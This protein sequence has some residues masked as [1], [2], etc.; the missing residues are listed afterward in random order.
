MMHAEAPHCMPKN[1]LIAGATGLVG[2]LLLSFCLKKD[3]YERIYVLL[4]RPKYYDDPRVVPVLVDY[5]RLPTYAGK[6]QAHHYYCCLGS[7]IRAAGSKANFYN[8]DALYVHY[9]AQLAQKDDLCSTFI[10]LTSVGAN[11][12]S[13]FFYCRVK[14]QAEELVGGARISGVHILRPS[15]LLGART[16]PRFYE[17]VA[18]ACI[19]VLRSLRLEAF[20]AVFAIAAAH[21]ARSMYHIAQQEQPGRRTYAAREIYRISAG[22]NP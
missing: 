7:T 2:K 11:S 22:M 14:G 19:A 17:E 13:S 12:R 15:V 20:A 9:L 4:R 10:L 6:W 1:A 8:V 18:K 5:D 21:V 16:P 3:D